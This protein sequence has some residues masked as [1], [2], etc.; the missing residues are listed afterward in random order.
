[1]S[2]ARGLVRHSELGIGEIA[3]QVGYS[4]VHEFSRD[5]RKH[6]ALAPTAD[7]RAYRAAGI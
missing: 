5:Y 1:M 2:L 4:R 3:R 7:R 6:F